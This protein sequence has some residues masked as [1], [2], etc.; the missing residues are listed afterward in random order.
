MG[1]LHVEMALW[2]TLGDLLDG[3]GWTTAL[4][5][6]EVTSSGVA[7]SLLRSSHLTRTR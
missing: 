3:A 1:G 4:T 6:A 2:D 7:D 5:E